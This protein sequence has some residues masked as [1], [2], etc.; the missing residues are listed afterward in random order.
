MTPKNRNIAQSPEQPGARPLSQL[1]DDQLIR[2]LT[3]A[4]IREREVTA[5]VVAHIAEFMARRLFLEY[6]CASIFAYLTKKLGYANSTAQNRIDAARILLRV[7]SLESDLVSGAIQL[8][9][10]AVVAQGLRQLT[11]E[12]NEKLGDEQLGSLIQKIKNADVESSAVTVGRE[13]DLS[14]QELEKTR[15]QKD[16][17]VR[18][19]LTLTEAQFEALKRVKSLSSHINP[20]ANWADVL[21]ILTNEYLRRKDP[22]VQKPTREAPTFY[23]PARKAPIVHKPTLRAPIVHKPQRKERTSPAAKHEAPESQKSR[24]EKKPF[25]DPEGKYREI[26]MTAESTSDPNHAVRQRTAIPMRTKR[27]VA[28]QGWCCEF[29][30]KRTGE[31]CES[32]FQLQ[33]DHI[34]SVSAGGGNE[35]SNLQVLCGVHNRL[36]FKRYG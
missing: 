36:K 35:Q 9:Q 30:D 25:R 17:S 29:V 2:N 5:E 8:T 3:A 33:F 15:H 11:R 12:R 4:S 21:E 10:I 26:T 32:T 28:A 34:K 24:R 19:E 20:Y 14:L 27:E 6:G 31:V 1:T 16:K 7:P 18:L 22:T 23:K 13:L